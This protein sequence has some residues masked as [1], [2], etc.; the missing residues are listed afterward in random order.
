MIYD[1]KTAV[2]AIILVLKENEIEAYPP[3][4]KKGECKS[5]YVV[6]KNSGSSQ[7]GGFSTEIHYIDVLCY[8][9]FNKYTN[10]EKFKKQV[11]Q[12]IHNNLYPRLMETGSET[13]D[14]YDEEIKGYMV[15]F[16]LRNNVRNKFI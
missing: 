13:A 6:V 2:E 11:K 3:A 1:D 8:V 9:P 7:L 16:M 10:L 4:I 14:Y 15:S 12:I 5:E